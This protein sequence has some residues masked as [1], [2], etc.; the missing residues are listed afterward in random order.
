MVANILQGMAE[1]SQFTRFSEST[2]LKQKRQYPRM[3]IR[4]ENGAWIGDP[5]AL[6]MFY[7]DLAAG[8]LEGWTGD[9]NPAAEGGVAC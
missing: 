9:D 4:K 7:K 3:P 2:L 8:K 1:I 5:E 6:E